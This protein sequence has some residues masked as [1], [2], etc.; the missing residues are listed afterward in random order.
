[1]K[2]NGEVVM[3]KKLINGEIN[4]KYKILL[5]DKALKVYYFNKKVKVIEINAVDV[6]YT[7]KK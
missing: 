3:D 5:G 4:R 7:I 6:Q 2:I 1:M